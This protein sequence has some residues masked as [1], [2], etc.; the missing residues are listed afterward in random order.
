MQMLNEIS[1]KYIKHSFN[2]KSSKVEYHIYGAG[3]NI[4][5]NSI[6]IDVYSKPNTAFNKKGADD[7]REYIKSSVTNLL[8]EYSAININ[9]EE[10]EYPAIEFNI[11][12]YESPVYSDI[13]DITNET[14]ANYAAVAASPYKV[15]LGHR[16]DFS[17]GSA[18]SSGSL[19]FWAKDTITGQVGAVASG[20][21]MVHNPSGLLNT[22]VYAVSSEG[23]YWLGQ[24]SKYS[25]G[26]KVDA[27]FIPML[28]SN[29]ANVSPTRFV[30]GRYTGKVRANTHVELLQ[31]DLV[32][33]SGFNTTT[34]LGNP[35]VVDA[36]WQGHIGMK[37]SDTVTQY[38][39]FEDYSKI[40]FSL[41]VQG[42][43]GGLVF[44]PVLSTSGG[45]FTIGGVI[46]A[47]DFTKYAYCAKAKNVCA[48]LG[49]QPIGTEYD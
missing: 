24:V 49:V 14:T 10:Y 47:T 9:I 27:C 11:P 40:N 16:L 21:M 17:K 46:A 39:W 38:L 30:G 48:A 19:A 18:S 20:H 6:N 8:S 12:K 36:Y 42:D 32:F 31:N 35:K 45:E 1:S 29:L 43:S 2:I 4:E 34:T 3:I 22:N 28:N 41:L 5:K 44:R 23:T 26:G 7:N 33:F 15:K 25:L 13:D 37:L